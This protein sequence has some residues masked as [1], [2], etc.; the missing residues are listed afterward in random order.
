MQLPLRKTMRKLSL[1]Q[2]LLAR[3]KHGAFMDLSM[4]TEFKSRSNL[5]AKVE[6]F[7]ATLP[8]HPSPE[9][10]DLLEVMRQWRAGLVFGFPESIPSISPARPTDQLTS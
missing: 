3:C 6:S 8:E 5:A 4:V 2:V 9:S 1:P 7:V 10:A